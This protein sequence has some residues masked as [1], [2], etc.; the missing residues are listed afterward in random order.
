MIGSITLKISNLINE[1]NQLSKYDIEKLNSMSEDAESIHYFFNLS[2][3][4]K[5]KLF[6]RCKTQM[7]IIKNDISSEIKAKEQPSSGGRR[8]TRKNKRKTRGKKRKTHGRK[9]K[10][11]RRRR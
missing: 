9:R 1:K 2:D 7:K 8:K 6:Q 3:F 10:T 4:D 5:I 11:H